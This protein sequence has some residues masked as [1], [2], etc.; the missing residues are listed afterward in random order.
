[1]NSTIKRFTQ[2]FYTEVTC[3]EGDLVKVSYGGYQMVGY[4]DTVIEAGV[5]V[6]FDN[7]RRGFYDFADL[8]PLTSEEL[9]ALD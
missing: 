6:T 5:Y 4:I 1:M 8:D 2:G 3:D 9:E 7:Y